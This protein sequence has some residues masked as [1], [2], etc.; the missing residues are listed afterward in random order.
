MSYISRWLLLVIRNFAIIQFRSNFVFG[1][2]FYT[3]CITKY[4]LYSTVIYQLSQGTG[5]NQDW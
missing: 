4:T 2:F 5:I 3:P 1:T